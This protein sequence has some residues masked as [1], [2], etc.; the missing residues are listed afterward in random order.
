MVPEAAARLLWVRTGAA[1]T[2]P[3]LQQRTSCSLAGFCRQGIQALNCVIQDWERCSTF[4]HTRRTLTDR[5]QVAG[6]ST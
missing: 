4:D 6:W 1:A 5:P 2:G 3:P